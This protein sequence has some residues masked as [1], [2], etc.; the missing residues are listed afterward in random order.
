MPTRHYALEQGG[1]GRLELR[2]EAPPI[3]NLT[4]LLDGEP[5]GALP[6]EAAIARSPTFALPDG[7]ILRVQP[8]HEPGREEA[9]KLTRNGVPLAEPVPTRVQLQRAISFVYLAAALEVGLSAAAL[10]SAP[11]YLVSELH[12]GWATLVL[13]AGVGAFG[14]LA[15]RAG[16]F[17]YPALVAAIAL[18]VGEGLF[19]AARSVYLEGGPIWPVPLRMLLALPIGRGLTAIRELQRGIR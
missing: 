18:I 19:I 14:F 6:D 12:L 11:P 16:R 8:G 5:V 9:V 3:R 10:W 17:A 2:F 7:S 4:L 1:S 15:S 13:G